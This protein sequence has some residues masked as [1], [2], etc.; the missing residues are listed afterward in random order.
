MVMRFEASTGLRAWTR[1]SDTGIYAWNV[2]WQPMH[3]GACHSVRPEFA[4]K[5]R[6]KDFRRPVVVDLDLRNLFVFH[7]SVTIAALWKYP[8]DKCQKHGN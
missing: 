7:R 1:S 2:P 3:G 4:L 6:C 8:F 5:V